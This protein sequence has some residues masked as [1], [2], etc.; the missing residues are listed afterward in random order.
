MR[1]L[2]LADLHYR[3]DWYHWLAAQGADLTVIAG[4]LLDGFSPGGLMPQML[5]L[6]G[7]CAKFPGNLAVS[8]GNHDGNE[9]GG[10]YDPEGL[11]DL[12]EEKR[13][14]L[15]PMLHAEHWM[16][17]LE[18]AGL[19]TDGR[20]SIVQ[21]PGGAVIVTTIP[22]N[23]W[24]HGDTMADEL[25]QEGQRLRRLSRTPW[26]VL[27][28]EP[29][30]DTTVGGSMG[31][32]EL[33]YKIREYRPNFVVSG[34]LHGQPYRGSFAD[35]IDGTWCFNPGCPV[36][37]RA[38]KSKIPNHIVLDLSARTATWRAIPNVGRVP[39]IKQIRLT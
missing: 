31:D 24:M 21:T 5:G 19:V 29:P 32:P 9:P 6:S 7:W 3:E 16:D 13:D 34:H 22:F 30:A 23:H 10:S 14:A 1:I 20:T 28:H 4:D 33:F 35:E 27:H 39:I 18:R 36:L 38:M 17:C 26:I 25:W 2:L 8:S 15:A 12:P 37:S 11:A